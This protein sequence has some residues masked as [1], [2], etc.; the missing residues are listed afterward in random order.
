MTYDDE[1]LYCMCAIETFSQLLV[2]MEG[3]SVVKKW[4]SS[5]WLVC[6]GSAQHT[7]LGV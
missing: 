6:L 1:S 3:V 5:A 7:L 4:C 2:D